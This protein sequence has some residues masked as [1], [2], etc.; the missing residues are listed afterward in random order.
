MLQEE[1]DVGDIVTV[2]PESIEVGQVGKV[3]KGVFCK[4]IAIKDKPLE[5]GEEL[6]VF[7][8]LQSVVSQVECCDGGQIGQG[9]DL[10]RYLCEASRRQ[11]KLAIFQHIGRVDM[12]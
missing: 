7:Q 2:Y 1:T 3:L 9:E 11:G 8:R 12:I 4:I 10:W 6:Y 5:S